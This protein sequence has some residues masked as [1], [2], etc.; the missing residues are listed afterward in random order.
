MQK[1]LAVSALTRARLALGPIIS[2]IA[3]LLGP[4]KMLCGRGPLMTSIAKKYA[5]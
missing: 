5:H 3:L 4:L 2:M 1:G